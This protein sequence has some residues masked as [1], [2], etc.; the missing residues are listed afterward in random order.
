MKYKTYNSCNVDTHFIH[1]C[2]YSLKLEFYPISY[3]RLIAAY[4][5]YE[6]CSSLYLPSLTISIY[7]N[8]I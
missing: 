7:S 1:L 5:K 4:Y 2:N 3:W 8:K 6:Y